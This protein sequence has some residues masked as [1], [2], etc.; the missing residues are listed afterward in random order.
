MK[1]ACIF[2]ALLAASAILVPDQPDKASLALVTIHGSQVSLQYTSINGNKAVLAILKLDD[3]TTVHVQL[4]QSFDEAQKTALAGM[5]K[6][7]ELH[8]KRMEEAKKTNDAEMLRSVQKEQSKEL[9]DFL[10]KQPCV[11]K[12]TLSIIDKKLVLIGTLHAVD[13]ADKE[14]V[15]AFG[16]CVIQGESVAADFVVG[17]SGKSGL[18]I[19]NG[20]AQIIV[21]GKTPGAVVGTIRTSGKLRMGDNGSVLLLADKIEIV[22]PKK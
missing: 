11:A 5:A 19:K 2:T 20:P 8:K 10:D 6:L 3:A 22:Q 13:A 15:P 18:A 12:G 14:N 9:I 21:S 7:I 1:M 4:S 17:K 16:S